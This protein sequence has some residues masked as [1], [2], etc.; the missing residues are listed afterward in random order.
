MTR[1][2]VEELLAAW[3]AVPKAIFFDGLDD[4]IVGIA[5]QYPSDPLVVYDER[6]IIDHFMDVEEMSEEEAWDWY[7]FNIAD[8]YAGPGTP[9]ILRSSSSS[10]VDLDRDWMRRLVL[11]YRSTHASRYVGDPQIVFDYILSLLGEGDLH[12]RYERETRELWTQP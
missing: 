3:E 11:R 12:R 10:P 2:E 6:K 9:L 5:S 8:L 4:A 7:G 1:E